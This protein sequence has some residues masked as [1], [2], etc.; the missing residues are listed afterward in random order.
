MLGGLIDRSSRGLP[1][2][3]QFSSDCTPLAPGSSC[4]SAV[5]SRNADAP[6]TTDLNARHRSAGAQ[7]ESFHRKPATQPERHAPL[8]ASL[9]G[10]YKPVSKRDLTVF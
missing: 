6:Q 2:G 5:R 7:L 8:L 1:N 9:G 10:R 4:I 3:A